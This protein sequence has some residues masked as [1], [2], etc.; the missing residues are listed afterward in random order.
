VTLI[1]ITIK[2]PVGKSI[3]I[4]VDSS[5]TIWNVKAKI[6]DVEEIP[7]DHQTLLFAAEQLKDSLTLA[8]YCIKNESTLHLLVT[9]DKTCDD[10]ISNFEARM[11][12]IPSNNHLKA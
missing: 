11:Q 6:Q 4:D 8:K 10:T 1:K 9:S 12:V 7:R 3:I 2:T 5:D